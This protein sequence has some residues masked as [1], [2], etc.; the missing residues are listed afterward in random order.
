[1][2]CK[3]GGKSPAIF[4]ITML[5]IILGDDTT[6]IDKHLAK[7][8]QNLT[9]PHLSYQEFDYNLQLNDAI[10]AMQTPPLWETTKI[11]A[12]NQC[13]LNNNTPS[14]NPHPQV[15]L[16][17]L[18]SKLDRRLKT[19]KNLL[20][21]AQFHQFDL[22]TQWED[23]KLALLIKQVAENYNL[24]LNQSAINYLAEALATRPLDTDKELYKLS[25]LS[26][27]P[28]LEQI[29][30]AIPSITKNC[31]LLANAMIT[32]NLEST[33][34]LVKQLL[35]KSHSKV[36]LAT[37]ITQ[38][39]T[40]L[41]AKIAVENNQTSNEAIAQ[42]LKLKNPNRAYYLKKETATLNSH[43]LQKALIQLTKLNANND[44]KYL[45]INLLLIV[46]LL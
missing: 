43:Q 44:F 25:L 46:R 23:K 42:L 5:T 2:T 40:W 17:L 18:T 24:T 14:L 45:E 29:T 15:H 35:L 6:S 32:K 36:I 8:K 1:M 39:R 20:K 38:F 30:S 31:L 16:V 3:Q 21:N 22:P 33:S 12:I 10:A 41:I 13:Q 26:T 19:V 27:H 7:L 4:S 34:E 37:L 28:T 11:I 9:S